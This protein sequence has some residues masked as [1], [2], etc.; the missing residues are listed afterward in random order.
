[1]PVE[2]HLS[3]E[4]P[5]THEYQV[6]LRLEVTP[7]GA[8][9][10][11]LP[12]WIPGSYM[13]R[14]FA[15]NIRDLRPGCTS[16]ELRIE[17]LDKQTWEVRGEGAMELV[18]RVYAL[19][20]S[21]RSA[22]FDDTRAYF[23]GTSLFLRVHGHEGEL[24]RLFIEGPT[25]PGSHAW[26]VATTLDRGKVDD[27]GFGLYT[28]PGYEALID[29]PVEIGN[30]DELSFDVEGVPHR[31]IFVEARGAD[32]GRVGRDVP[33]ICQEHVSMFGELPVDRYLFQT[34][35]T[36]DGY[37]GLE[38]HDS[39]S[40]I[41]KRSDLP[42]PGKQDM[43]KGYRQYLALC[44]H[45]YFHLWNVKRIRPEQFA[46]AD[47]SREVHSELLWA[48][49]G[50]TSYYDE[51]ALARCGLVS[52]SDYLD[53]LAPT[54]TRYLRNAGRKRQSVAEAS[55]DAWTKF[56]KQDESAPNAIV[57]YYNKG[58]LVALGLDRLIRLVSGDR[59]C[60]D[61]LMRRLWR[62]Y[63][64]TGKG[65]PERS[66]ENEVASL[67]GQP[68]NEF[69]ERYVYGV[70]ELPLANWLAAYG[71]GVHV[72]P[73]GSPQD[74][75]GYIERP[76]SVSPARIGLGAQTS[77]RDGLVRI[78]RVFAGGAAEQAGLAPGDLLMAIAG[79][80]C[81][82]ETLEELL[83][84]HQAGEKVRLT[85]FRRDLLREVELSIVPSAADTADLYWLK[86]SELTEGAAGRRDRWLRSSSGPDGG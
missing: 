15:R 28:A 58:A 45:E 35:A 30:F 42:W 60:L 13:I 65:V 23:N 33:R 78:D 26:R 3:L 49:E 69:F 70:E 24:H 40:L 31:M 77:T 7:Q 54:L 59:L 57:S 38:H 82:Q 53:M 10:L 2:Y 79:E 63:G 81:R 55:F 51:L 12:A 74:F 47:L 4:D 39:T 83:A 1:M 71:V 18:Y 86:E 64:T 80:R 85:V 48:F 5:H 66:I 16:G 67:I 43:D 27:R 14:D 41:C 37:G 56:Y 8:L 11:S 25:F 52:R 6:T 22:Y 29:C 68:A 32:L 61:D 50:I 19:D 9:R 72:R 46:G 34:L 75:G 84:R 62:R 21:V 17:K 44:S 76:G 36:P 73:G 20:E